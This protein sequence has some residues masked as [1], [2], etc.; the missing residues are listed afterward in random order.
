[1][2]N[3][4]KKTKTP[5]PC[6]FFFFP[7]SF[8]KYLKLP[9]LIA[10]FLLVFYIA[11]YPFSVN[12]HK[13][14]ALEPPAR[15]FLMFW[16]WREWVSIYLV[17]VFLHARPFS[18]WNLIFYGILSNGSLPESGNVSDILFI[19]YPLKQW[20]S[21]SFPLYYNIKFVIILL[22]NSFAGYFALRRITKREDV[23]IVSGVFMAVNPFLVMMLAKARLRA[24]I[25]GFAIL[26]IYYLYEITQKYD[27]KKAVLCGLFLGL[28]S[29]F[30]AFYGI[31]LIWI[32][33]LVFIGKSILE[34]YRKKPVEIWRFFKMSIVAFVAFA[35][36]VLP[37]MVPY[38]TSVKKES[39]E[40]QAFGVKFF[41]DLPTPEEIFNPDFLNNPENRPLHPLRLIMV[42]Q[43]PLRFYFPVFFSLFAV[44]AFFKPRPLVFLLIF[45][46]LLFYVLSL[47]PYLK[48]SEH[49]EIQGFYRTQ[50]GGFIPLP[51]LLFFKYVPFISRLHHPDHFLSFSSIALLFLV[52]LGM[53]NVLNFFK[54]RGKLVVINYVISVALIVYLV[55]GIKWY[56]PRMKYQICNIKIPQLYYKIAKEPFCGIYEVPIPNFTPGMEEIYDR[57]EFYQSIHGKKYI[58]FRHPGLSSQVPK[59]GGQH[60]MFPRDFDKL[61]RDNNRFQQYLLKCHEGERPRYTGKDIEQVKELGYKYIILHESE[62]DR[63][64]RAKHRGNEG[65][66]AFNYY[67][68]TKKHLMNS[69]YFD[70]LGEETEYPTNFIPVDE[71]FPDYKVSVFRIKK[72]GN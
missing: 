9:A 4:R 64:S 70:L 51:Y 44:F 66:E 7:L 38:L 60:R 25:M 47:G 62:F 5:F 40:F 31:F 67:K 49:Y 52:G 46:F 69:K 65:Q 14:V 18:L 54:N 20:L 27:I 29:I 26:C 8:L 63:A 10:G 19:S 58:Q 42:E 55:I 50:N 61:R 1:M 23:G 28:T 16:M 57:T 34:L 22:F 12:I 11:Y 53:A 43:M 3:G 17:R 2:D 15:T 6:S 45:I 35:I 72:T 41:R 68:E 56:H 30:Y 24:G 48:I 37:W 39:G 33:A 36:I 32:I 71:V 21:L 13:M 59:P